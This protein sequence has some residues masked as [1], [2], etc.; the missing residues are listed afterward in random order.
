MHLRA[1]CT[2]QYGLMA[3][4]A[5]LMT[6]PAIA[7][8]DLKKELEELRERVTDLED[9]SDEV[10]EKL[11]SRALAK[12]FS[13]MELS[14]GGHIVNVF[15]FYDGEDSSTGGHY[16]MF[17]ELFIRAQ[18]ADNWS[19]MATPGFYAASTT[20][21]ADPNNP[22][23]TKSLGSPTHG[24]LT[25]RAYLEYSDSD[26]L[27]VRAGVFGTPHG[28]INRLY[29][30][31]SRLMMQTPMME[32]PF[33]ANQVYAQ[34]L[35]GVSAGG[36][37]RVGE[38][39]DR[40]EYDAYVGVETDDPADQEI[41]GRVAYHSEALSTTFSLNAGGGRRPDF[42]SVT[43]R[44]SSF[45]VAVANPFPV[46]SN[47]R[48]RYL[49]Y[50][51]ETETNLEKAVIKTQLYKSSEEDLQDKIGGFAQGTYFVTPT[52]GLTYRFDYYN[53]GHNRGIAREHGFGLVW[54]VAS[55][56]RFQL[57]GFHQQQPVLDADLNYILAGFSVAF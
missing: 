38:A 44:P 48:N 19:L 28:V 45:N 24:V 41:G 50:G 34:Y 13:A 17:T 7:Q 52:V 11:G 4:L 47:S 31:P 49:F 22:S 18:V 8:E 20:S 1:V 2:L 3:V 35:A 56:V 15:P 40:F 39:G 33:T 6:A 30:I 37:L 21:Q 43:G 27:R 5:S 57:Q 14:V 53:A 26:E 55:N 54:D 51:I 10:D 12:A 42:T 46:Y 23:I 29:F 32:R 9:T 16:A 25:T 36:K